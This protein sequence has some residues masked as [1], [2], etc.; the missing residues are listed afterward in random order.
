MK[1][2]FRSAYRGLSAHKLPS[3]GSHSERLSCRLSKLDKGPSGFPVSVRRPGGKVQS[4]KAEKNAG[5]ETQTRA[6]EA[7]R[8]PSEVVSNLQEAFIR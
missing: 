6:R 1:K 8:C 3:S 2:G 7:R 4:E 5:N